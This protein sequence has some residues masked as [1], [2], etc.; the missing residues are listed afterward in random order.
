MRHVR[1][2]MG[3]VEHAWLA[4]IA[5]LERE[6]GL[7]NCLNAANPGTLRPPPSEA[8]WECSLRTVIRG[9]L[10]G[11][12]SHWRVC[13]R[14][15]HGEQQRGGR[16]DAPH[17]A[18][19][20]ARRASGGACHGCAVFRNAYLSGVPWDGLWAAY[21]GLAVSLLRAQLARPGDPPCRVG[22]GRVCVCRRPSVTLQLAVMDTRKSN[23][24]VFLL[25]VMA[26]LT[27]TRVR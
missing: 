14:H 7:P 12:V 6:G 26:Q 9:R 16:R 27:S 19:N 8:L 24:C 4:V 22:T 10:S 18:S 1:L 25:R 20:R 3:G 2:G 21:F 13:V 23:R 5:A 15:E 11:R 17:P